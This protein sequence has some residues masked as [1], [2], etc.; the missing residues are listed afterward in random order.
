M[1][2]SK[3]ALK[4]HKKLA[5]K[6][7][8][9]VKEEVLSKEDLSLVYTPGVSA[10]CLE[11]AEDKEKVYDYTWKGNSVAV[12]TDGTAV[13]GMGNIGPEAS[14]PVME[15]KAALFKSFANIDAVPIALD[16]QDTEEIIRTVKLLAPS[17]GGI[18]LEDISAPRCVEI[19]RRLDEELDI[20]VYHDDQHGTAIVVLAALINALKLAGKDKESIKVVISGTGAAGSAIIKILSAYGIS[21]IVAFDQHGMVNKES[22]NLDE[23]QIELL[24]HLNDDVV[25]KNLSEAMVGSDVFIGVSVANLLSIEMVESMAPNAIVFAMAN[26]NPEISYDDAKKAGALIVGTGRSDRPN[27]INNVLVFPGLFKG[28]LMSRS[29]R[30]PV[31]LR[32]ASAEIIASLTKAEDISSEH[33]ITDVFDPNLVTKLSSGIVDVVEAL[34]LEGYDL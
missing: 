10:P 15:G 18:N 28:L 13:L 21:D 8:M 16:T 12:I 3:E 17:F 33:I 29:K 19:E 34:R 4:L 14:L 25:Y 1:D 31:E 24:N 27:Q 23:L 6:I 26:P 30:V 32:V 11:I 2:V 20:P 9:N 7:E 22:E 5:G